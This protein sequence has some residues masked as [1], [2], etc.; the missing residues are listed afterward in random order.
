MPLTIASTWSDDGAPLDS[1]WEVVYQLRNSD[2]SVAVE[3]VSAA[4][5]PDVLLAD[6]SSV[7]D[8]FWLSPEVGAGSYTLSVLVRDPAGERS[9]LALVIV[10]VQPDGSYPLGSVE[11]AVGNAAAPGLTAHKTY[12]PLSASAGNATSVFNSTGVFISTARVQAIRQAVSD[13]RAPNYAAYERLLYECN[14]AMRTAP[15]PP[16]TLYV[17]PFYENPDGHGRAKEAVKND[18]N[19][20]YALALCYRITGNES[21]AQAGARVISAWSTTLTKMDTRDDTTLVFSYH[22]PSM[23]FAADLL[24]GAPPYTT[25][26]D[27]RFVTFLKT[28]ALQGSSM[29]TVSRVG[30]GYKSGVQLTN[31]WSDWGTVLAMSIGVFTADTQ[32]YAESVQKWRSNVSIQIDD[33]GNLPIEGRRNNCSGDTGLHYTNYA[34][35][36]LTIAAEIAYNNGTDLYQ[37]QR[38]QRAIHRTAEVDRYP[39]RFPFARHNDSEYVDTRYKVAWLEVARNHTADAN[40]DWLLEQ[41]RPVVTTEVIRYATVTH[42]NLQVR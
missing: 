12:L 20:A 5:L 10:S 36:P 14:N 24:R 17:P 25:A 3:F 40:A 1:R 30:C 26:I 8:E 31:N 34:M 38:Y 9:P 7:S 32:L 33:Q 39:S 21:F 2:T 29:N 22:F 42:G 41:F 35:Q 23:I 11:V 16:R 27:Q 15:N 37:D 6:A 18:S 13:R 19:N 28:T 4:N